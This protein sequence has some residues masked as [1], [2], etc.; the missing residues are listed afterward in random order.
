MGECAQKLQVFILTSGRVD[1]QQTLKS[2]SCTSRWY[3]SIDLKIVIP[4]SEKVL[5]EK[6]HPRWVSFLHCVNENWR[7]EDIRQHVL[8]NFQGNLHLVLDDD[9]ILYR[10]LEARRL[11]KMKN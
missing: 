10:K 11:E 6:A 2:L 3:E 9:L 5:W 4:E 8:N 7:V 1:H